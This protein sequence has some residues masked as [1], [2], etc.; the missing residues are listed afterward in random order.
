MLV[1]KKNC[2]KKIES[3]KYVYGVVL[4]ERETYT[5]ENVEFLRFVIYTEGITKRDFDREDFFNAFLNC[6]KDIIYSSDKINN[7]ENLLQEIDLLNSIVIDGIY[8]LI[9]FSDN[10]EEN[11]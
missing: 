5:E 7:D 1:L 9:D 11:I 8:G 10:R 4:T 6:V 3:K 2:F